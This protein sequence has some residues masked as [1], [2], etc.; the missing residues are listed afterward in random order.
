M[1]RLQ[2]LSL[3]YRMDEKDSQVYRQHAHQPDG[4]SSRIVFNDIYPMVAMWSSR[5]EYF[6]FNTKNLKNQ[7][8]C[9]ALENKDLVLRRF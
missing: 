9:L 3:K 2:S 4:G 8:K 5:V 7:L 1:E 6:N